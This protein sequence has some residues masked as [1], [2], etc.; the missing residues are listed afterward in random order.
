MLTHLATCGDSFGTGEGLPDETRFEHSF[1]G[2]VSDHFK[3]EQQVYARSGCCN[4]TIYLQVKKIVEQAKKTPYYK[5]FKPFVLITTTFHE[6]LI[7]PLD[8]G[9][10]YKNPDLSDVEYLSYGPYRDIDMQQGHGKKLPFDANANPRLITE[11]VSNI[12]WYQAGKAP[13][14]SRLF[15]KI[16]PEKFK[17]IGSYFLNLFDTGVKK[18]QDDALFVT[19]HIM[20][21]KAGIPHVLMGH[22]LPT[23]IDE[24]NRLENDWGYYTKNYPD[25]RGSSHCNEEGNALVGKSIID[26]I[27]KYNL[28]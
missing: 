14:I 26:H 20:L 15:E 28:I 11:T 12:Q 3:L 8:D 5:P 19:M 7:I 4:F 21:K 18:E 16:H 13:G 9:F 1:A 22:N 24:Q 17:A 25:N 10:K 2:V 6:R 23:L 27:K